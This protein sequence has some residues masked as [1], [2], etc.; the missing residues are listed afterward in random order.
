M[1]LLA[2]A[3]LLVLLLP[4]VAQATPGTLQPGDAMSSSVGGC[5]LNFVFDGTGALAGKV[6]IGTAAHCVSE[7]GESIDSSPYRSFGTV[8][9]IGDAGRAATDWAFIEVK[10]AFTPYVRAAVKGHP[11]YPTGVAT[12]GETLPGDPVQLSGYGMVFGSSAPTQE[13]RV[14]AI[15]IH[16]PDRLQ[17]VAP[18]V[19]GDSG[20][21]IVHIPSGGAISLNSRLCA[22]G[23]CT[24]IGPTF[25]SILD[26]AAARGFTVGLRTVQN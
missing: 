24:E 20:G 22:A 1:R 10:P 7:V 17:I 5:T 6:Y 18:V 21:P 12:L 26:Q 13:K 4:L 3:A 11:Q 23:A 19:F 14:G 2:P 8:A 9:I 25:E 15:S 16:E